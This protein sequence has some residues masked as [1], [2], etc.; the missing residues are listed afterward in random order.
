MGILMRHSVEDSVASST[1]LTVKV[2]SQNHLARTFTY[3]L[4]KVC[5]TLNYTKQ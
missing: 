3:C 2:L 4:G 5:S 1:D